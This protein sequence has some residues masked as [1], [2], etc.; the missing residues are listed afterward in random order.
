M[1]PKHR[2]KFS[3]KKSAAKN[4]VKSSSSRFSANGPQDFGL[5]GSNM[6]INIRLGSNRALEKNKQPSMLTA[7][8]SEDCLNKP[9]D[10]SDGATAT[11]TAR[12]IMSDRPATAGYS[13]SK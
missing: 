13:L 9:I 12:M 8:K 5:T 7:C 1:L 6:N 2:N 3:S 4:E 10:N 11:A